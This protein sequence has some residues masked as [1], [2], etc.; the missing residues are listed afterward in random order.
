MI[1]A[2]IMDQCFGGGCVGEKRQRAVTS[3][4]RRLTSTVNLIP[5]P[6][7]IQ[8]DALCDAATA[9]SRDTGTLTAAGVAILNAVSP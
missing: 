6:I 9:E 3:V 8:C 4:Y 5:L 2:A 1:A 7:C